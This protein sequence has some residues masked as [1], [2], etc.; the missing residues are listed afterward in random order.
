MTRSYHVRAL[1]PLHDR[2]DRRLEGLERRTQRLQSVALRPTASILVPR[3][4]C[5]TRPLRTARS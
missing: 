3:S 4:C 1:H 2:F 5:A